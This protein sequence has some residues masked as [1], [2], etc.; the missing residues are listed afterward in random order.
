MFDKLS[1]NA[2]SCQS[3]DI[4]ESVPYSVP[5]PVEPEFEDP[6]NNLLIVKY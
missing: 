2:A 6:N 4:T 3:T 5:T 1:F